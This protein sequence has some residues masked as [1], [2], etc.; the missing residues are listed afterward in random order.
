MEFF[1]NIF[2]RRRSETTERLLDDCVR[3]IDDDGE[4]VDLM[5]YEPL[6]D[7]ASQ[8]PD[9]NCYN[10]A[11]LERWMKISS[12]DPMTGRV[13]SENDLRL[14]RRR[15]LENGEDKYHYYKR[16]PGWAL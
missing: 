14:V 1:R 11:N 6:E 3:N 12:T 4:H 13:I 10:T 5:S 16:I 7:N 2:L 15:A 8:T 9:G